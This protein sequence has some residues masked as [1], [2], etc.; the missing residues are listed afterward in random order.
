V[1]NETRISQKFTEISIKD[2]GCG[3]S[4]ENMKKIFNPFFTTKGKTDG[5][6]MG[7]SISKNIIENHNGEMIVKQRKNGGTEFIIKLPLKNKGN[8]NEL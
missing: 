5:T 3:I 1:T 2:T 8:S 7:L 4:D 6:G